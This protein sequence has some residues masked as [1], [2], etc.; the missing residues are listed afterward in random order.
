MRRGIKKAAKG[1]T[2]QD[3][4]SECLR[5]EA[6][7]RLQHCIISVSNAAVKLISYEG[8]WVCW[9]TPMTHLHKE[10]EARLVGGRA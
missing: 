9:M 1:N 6:R 4:T 3:M 2:L 10:D 8:E 5:V 7:A